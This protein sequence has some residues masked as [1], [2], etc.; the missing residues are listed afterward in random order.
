MKASI[1]KNSLGKECFYIVIT[2][3]GG[4]KWYVSLDMLG[5]DMRKKTSKEFRQNLLRKLMNIINAETV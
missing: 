2:D 1:P 3:N 5:A 4:K